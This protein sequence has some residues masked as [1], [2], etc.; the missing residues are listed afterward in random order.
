MNFFI[1]LLAFWVLSPPLAL[2]AYK[3]PSKSITEKQYIVAGEYALVGASVLLNGRL[4][5]R[6]TSFS[7]DLS[8]EPT[9]ICFA[10][11]INSWTFLN[12]IGSVDM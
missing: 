6:L 1:Y 10:K 2:P 8:M 12:V 11:V 5:Q 9:I 4:K 7:K 3:D